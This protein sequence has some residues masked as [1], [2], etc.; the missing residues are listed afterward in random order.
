MT[1]RKQETVDRTRCRQR[2]TLNTT[3]KNIPHEDVS[4]EDNVL[5]ILLDEASV[6]DDD[7][8]EMGF[9]ALAADDAAAAIVANT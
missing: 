5:V 1:I 3:N 2:T 6:A 9:V 7:A 4:A 8:V